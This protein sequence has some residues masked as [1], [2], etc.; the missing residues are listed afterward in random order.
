MVSKK[1]DSSYRILRAAA[2][3]V[4]LISA[5]T[6][7]ACS[8][9]SSDGGGA[10]KTTY[11]GTLYMASTSGGHIAVIPVT[12]DPSNA[13]APFTFGNISRIQ[14][15]SGTGAANKTHNFHDV[16]VNGN[17]LIYSTIMMDTSGTATDGTA[18]VGAIDLTG[19]TCP[20]YPG[21]CTFTENDATIDINAGAGMIYCGSGLGASHFV[22]MTMSYPAYIDAIPLS[23]IT[24]GAT[25]PRQR[26]FVEDFRAGGNG[27]YIFAH[28]V[29]NPAKSKLFV[30][31]NETTAG[32]GGLMAQMTGA[33]TAYLLDMNDVVGGT[34]DPASV[35]TTRSISGMATGGTTIAFRSTFTPDGSKILQAG[36]DRLLVLDG[37][38][39]AELDNNTAIGGSAAAIENHDA[40]PTPDGKYAILAL[41]FKHAAADAAQDS[42]L[43]L[44][45]LTNKQTIGEPVSTCNGCHAAGTTAHLTCGVDGKLTTVTQ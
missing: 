9:S 28:G 30:A 43:Q 20:N 4:A 21:S 11:T 31:V 8:S 40:M 27:D 2:C 34:V 23:S 25:L 17:S 35:T 39:L 19:V 22:P 16:R 45:D 6:F 38:S 41:R 7:A 18:H 32:N 13:T 24:N 10:T 3:L 44:Y 14:L 42:G 5:V 1:N 36:R 29:N 26:T 15:S 33:V 37:N 12:I